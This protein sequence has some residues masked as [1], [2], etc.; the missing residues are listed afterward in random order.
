M[1]DWLDLTVSK[2]RQETAA[3]RSVWLERPHGAPLPAWGPGAHIKIRLPGGDD[4]SYS[5]V[6]FSTDAGAASAPNCYRLGV[7]L[8]AQSTG[9]SRHVHGLAVGDRVS[10]SAPSNDFAL[11]PCAAPVVLVAGGIGVTP[12]A[13]MAAQL[14]A[15]GAPFRL[16][17]LGR[18]AGSMAFVD[19]LAAVAGPHL[20][21]HDDSRDGPFDLAGLMAGLADAEPLYLC[22]PRGLIDAAVAEAARLGWPPG[23]LHFEIF[24]AAPPE[25][26]DQPFEL[27]LAASGCTL[28]VPADQTIL[29]TMIEAGLDPMYDCKRGDCGICQATVLD[30]LPDHRDY[31]LSG[32]ERD[33]GTLI[34]ICVSRSKT[35]RLVLDL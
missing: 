28:T 21:V 25:A 6:N 11:E 29:D 24:A 16:H 13:G 8:D 23:R 35:Q 7:L 30:G 22:G 10:V 18:A 17:Y 1:T 26:G 12:I 2:V 27:V 32:A 5:L 34:Q 31:I 19:E 15:A 4:R 3:I 9:G 33:A 14:A 20:R